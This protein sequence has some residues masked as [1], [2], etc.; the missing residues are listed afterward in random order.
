M[1]AGELS[2]DVDSPDAFGPGIVVIG[3]GTADLE[4]G[5]RPVPP[6]A[7]ELTAAVDVTPGTGTPAPRRPPD[8]DISS[9]HEQLRDQRRL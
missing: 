2:I 4:L 5:R 1:S 7:G 8:P 3:D 6:S 9:E